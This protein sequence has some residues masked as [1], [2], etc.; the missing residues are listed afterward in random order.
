MG[1]N[2]RRADIGMAEQLLYGA[3]VVAALQQVG[4]ERMAQRVRRGG[5]LDTG[6][7]ECSLEGALD[8]LILD[9]MALRGTAAR[10]DRQLG[11]RK[12]PEPCPRCGGAGIFA[13]ERV[14]HVDAAMADLA[15][16]SP[17]RAS[18][19][20]LL[21]QGRNQRGRQHDDAV[22]RALA[23]TNDQRAMREID[24]LHPQTQPLH[25][26]HAGAVQQLGDQLL[27]ATQ[28]R[29]QAHHLVLREH[30]GQPNTALGPADLIHPRQIEAQHLLIEEQQSRQRL[31]MRG[32]R[33]TPLGCEPGQKRFDL[34][35]TQ[36]R[37][38]PHLMEAH[39][40]PYPMEIGLLRSN[41][42]VQIANALAH[43]I[44]KARRLQRRE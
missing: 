40:G 9:V 26:A 27:F 22:L 32:H 24:I 34:R 10:I 38:M 5:L 6:A 16:G 4:G 2:H 8:A 11:M 23:F 12:H 18:A 36:I 31:L 17:Q 43:L 35:A 7:F 15:I 19:G 42:V 13:I 37:R 33:D 28:G 39:K 30:D 14:G 44:E 3:N 25:D 41:A 29:E 20:H 21:A 1:V